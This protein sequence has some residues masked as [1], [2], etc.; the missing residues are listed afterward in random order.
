M[1]HFDSRSI[2]QCL[3]HMLILLS[4]FSAVRAQNKTEKASAFKGNFID[5]LDHAFDVS[6]FLYKPE[7]FIPVP[8]VITEPAVGYGGGGAL[9]FFNPNDNMLGQAPPNIT[10]VAGFGTQN[11]TWGA[12]LFHMHILKDDQ[13]R[14]LGAA[15][16]ADIHI[17]FYGNQNDY[18]SLHP[19]NLN[20]DAWILLLRSMFRIK[21]SN[22]FFG[23]EYALFTTQN[24]IDTLADKP[25][26]NEIIKKL[27]GSSTISMLTLKAN[28]DSRNNIFSPT[29]GVD[30]GLDFSFNAPWLGA[31]NNSQK[32]NTYFLGYQTLGTKVFPGFRYDGIFTYGDT[33]LYALPFVQL[34]GAPMMRYQSKNVI[35]AETEW[36]VNVFR[37]YSLVG[38]AGTGKAF[39]SLGEF[40]DAQWVYNYGLGARYL[41]ARVFGLQA[42]VDFAWSNE[43]FAFYLTIGSAWLR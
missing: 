30:A 20:L 21:D 5:T 6:S 11:G 32:L 26:I 23:M 42:G 7:G 3:L 12:G 37:R 39:S 14:L 28:Y 38:F 8:F 4:L 33:P 25:I 35:I 10:G 18:L 2:K 31:S 24:S 19:I 34:R 13:I 29:I 15:F 16:K 36:R 9:L 43:N 17:N 27:H 40:N 22:L 1:K 41:L